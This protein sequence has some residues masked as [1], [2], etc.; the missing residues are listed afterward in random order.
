MARGTRAVVQ[1][2][3]L[4][5][6]VYELILA[7]LKS[8]AFQ[9]GQRLLEVELAEKYK[10]SRTP[11]REAL[12]QLSR[13]GLLFGNERG[14][15]APTYTKKDALDR[16][17]VKRLLDPQLA[18]H[19]ATEAEPQQLRQLAK[20]HE[21][22]KAAHAAG[23]VN[24]FNK[25]NHDFRMLHRNLCRNTLLVRCVT[26]VD[27]QFEIARHQIHQL[28]ENRAL[29][30]NLNAALLKSCQARDQAAAREAMM[31]FLDFLQ[32]YYEEHAPG[33]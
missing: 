1:V 2:E 29:S 31:S 8:G 28:A 20:H 22:E 17:E 24:A 16:L 21:Q 7:D 5:D 19:A 33:D 6:Q 4:R 30:I 15:V 12:F 32:V 26:L 27:D 13:E 14:Y 25:A 18:E 9:P 11:V 3:R 23:K 10:V